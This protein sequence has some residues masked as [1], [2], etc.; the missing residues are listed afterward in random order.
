MMIDRRRF[1]A[2]TAAGVAAAA[3]SARVSAGAYLFADD[4][5]GP[6]GSAPD[7]TK[8]LHET[9]NQTEYGYDDSRGIWVNDRLNSFLDGNSNLVVRITESRG[10]YA[11]ARLTTRS[12][13][14]GPIGTTWE[15]RIK[16]DPQPGTWPA[17]WTVGTNP[18]D[19]SAAGKGNWPECGEIDMLEYFS[20]PSWKPQFATTVNA[21]NG[22]GGT[23]ISQGGLP[24]LDTN[25][26]IYRMEWSTAGFTFYQDGTHY[27]SVAA[28][29]LPNWPYNE[30]N[31][32]YMILNQ[33]IGGPGGGN[34]SG[35]N[36]PVDM[37]VDYIR[38]WAT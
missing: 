4:F 5:D 24:T 6:A 9:G 32:Q 7:P 11:S 28:N 10:T 38:V 1:V 31:P 37:I 2:I 14:S 22:R 3:C 19:G 23:N 21:D 29:S 18:P 26:H 36:F 20:N 34:P 17:W 16:I 15:A 8:W 25:W 30:D 33:A 13:W 12:I 35:T 27:F